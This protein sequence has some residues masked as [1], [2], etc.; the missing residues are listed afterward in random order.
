MQIVA[1]IETVDLARNKRLLNRYRFIEYE[2]LR[3]LA[4]WLPATARMEFK[5]AMGRFISEEAQHMHHLY[6]RLRKVQTPALRPPDEPALE[7]LMAKVI[8]A[9]S[10]RD[11]LA[12][13]FSILAGDSKIDGAYD[14]LWVRLGG[15][16]E[17]PLRLL[18]S[19]Q[20]FSE[21]QFQACKQLL[22]SKYADWLPA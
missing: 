8:N 18:S 22:A 2:T 6:R 12:D 1:P 14:K 13:L 5:L 16:E 21:A 3:I 17:M 19:Y 20:G 11:L 7:D 15:F 4:A 10:E 9:P